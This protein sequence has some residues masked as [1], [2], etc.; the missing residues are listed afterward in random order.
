MNVYVG[1]KPGIQR[2]VW[3]LFIVGLV[4][5]ILAASGVT[6]L[7]VGFAQDS[8]PKAALLAP[9]ATLLAQQKAQLLHKVALYSGSWIG[10]DPNFIISKLQINSS[11]LNIT[12]HVIGNC[13]E[14]ANSTCNLSNMGTYTQMYSGEPL[15]I[16]LVFTDNSGA[17]NN[18]PLVMTLRN[19]SGTQLQAVADYYTG[20]FDK[21]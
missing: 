17:Q 8:A 11:G 18:W 16:Q 6:W 10:Q 20:I 9:K 2:S 12:V 15:T 3:V 14:A 13:G 7:L 19:T 4:G 21:T 1:Q 5:L